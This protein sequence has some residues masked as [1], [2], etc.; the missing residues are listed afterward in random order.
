ELCY[1]RVNGARQGGETL[2]RAA[3][4]ESG[5][6]GLAAL[7]RLRRFLARYAEPATPFRSW[8]WPERQ[9]YAGDYDHL[10][11][12]WEWRVLGEAQGDAT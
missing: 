1:V 5:E 8:A 10:A 4:P 12:V 6:M 3:F 7:E 11:R 9:R 2:V